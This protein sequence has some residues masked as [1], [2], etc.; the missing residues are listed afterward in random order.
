MVLTATK[1]S[2]RASAQPLKICSNRT[3]YHRTSSK[4]SSKSRAELV[5]MPTEVISSKQW[6]K[7]LRDN[8]KYKTRCSTSRWW[9]IHQLDNFTFS[10]RLTLPS[11][12]PLVLNKQE[13][14]LTKW[15]KC[16]LDKLRSQLK[17]IKC[18]CRPKFNRFRSL[19]SLSLQTCNNIRICQISSK[20]LKMHRSSSN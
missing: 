10:N 11:R 14:R 12:Q 2:F 16:Q 15:A 5:W 4:L 17:A 7:M 1:C 20:A 6:S 9:R 19:A 3:S 13:H 8:P 18:L